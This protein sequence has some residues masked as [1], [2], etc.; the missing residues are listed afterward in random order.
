MHRVA[1]GIGTVGKELSRGGPS[2]QSRMKEAG[3][4]EV[5]RHWGIERWSRP[6]YEI[7]RLLGLSKTSEWQKKTV[8]QEA[9]NLDQ[10]AESSR[11]SK[12]VEEE[13]RG[14]IEELRKDPKMAQMWLD[15]IER[16]L[17]A[18]NRFAGGRHI[19]EKDVAKVIQGTTGIP[20]DVKHFLRASFAGLEQY[21][22]KVGDRGT[23][24]EEWARK[25]RELTERGVLKERDIGATDK[26]LG[27]VS[28]AQEG[29]TQK[30]IPKSRW[31]ISALTGWGRRT[32]DEQNSNNK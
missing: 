19:S 27:A 7:A 21:Q 10:K 25:S 29:E 22:E 32:G 18:N 2:V 13:V 30:P 16:N 31:N 4:G 14:K 17:L 12:I 26:S 5:Y 1:R 24:Q 9:R 28:F 11:M 3:F 6:G 20:N 15:K 23:T 8:Q